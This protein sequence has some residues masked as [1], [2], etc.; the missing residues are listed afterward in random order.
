MTPVRTTPTLLGLLLTLPPFAHAAPLLADPT[1]DAGPGGLYGLPG[2]PV[3]SSYADITGADATPVPGGLEVTLSLASLPA[4]LPPDTVWGVAWTLGD[5]QVEVGWVDL[6]V[7][8]HDA[9]QGPYACLAKADAPPACEPIP[10]ERL[11]SGFRFEVPA[12]DLPPGKLE[13]VGAATLHVASATAWPLFV[14]DMTGAGVL[15]VA[16]G[17]D[18]PLATTAA[19]DDPSATVASASVGATPSPSGAWVVAGAL[20]LAALCV[21]GAVAWRKRRA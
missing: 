1:G 9:A 10:G 8:G 19:P 2:D 17:P 11:A 5:Q 12:K 4:A 6:L 13:G 16:R 20:A 15:D 7:P 14:A 21:A 3:A 18:F